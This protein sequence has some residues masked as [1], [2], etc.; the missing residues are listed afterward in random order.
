MK[1]SQSQLLAIAYSYQ[2]LKRRDYERRA[3]GLRV[4]RIFAFQRHYKT[5]GGFITHYGGDKFTVSV[6]DA[7]DFLKKRITEFEKSQ[8]SLYHLEKAKEA[9]GQCYDYLSQYYYIDEDYNI[10]R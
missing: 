4:N 5:L 10:I 3:I 8:A 7:V 2:E 6:M 9:L 1:R